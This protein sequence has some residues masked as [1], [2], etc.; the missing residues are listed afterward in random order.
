MTNHDKN[1]VHVSVVL[2]RSGSM[3]SIADDVVGGYN[4]FLAKQRREAGEARVTLVQFDSD[5]PFEVLVD[6][7]DLKKVQDLDRSRYE[8]RSTTP[9]FDA[10]GRM[11]AR[12]DA[13]I[14]RR[15]ADDLPAEDQVVVIITDGLENASREYDRA[16]VFALVD[17]RAQEQ[18]WTFVFLG[19]NQNAYEEGAKVGVAAGNTADWDAS[20]A[21]TKDMFRKLSQAT[22][23]Y[24][25]KPSMQRVRDK[26]D[27]LR[28]KR[29]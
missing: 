12:I 11:I 9:L 27:Y 29:D 22:A 15:K 5:D 24:R 18:D 14:A 10:V 8:P 7:V 13:G 2:D 23:A 20:A 16:T 1:P 21:G 4:E 19:A 3:S 28:G 25:G 6:G 17:Q 26:A